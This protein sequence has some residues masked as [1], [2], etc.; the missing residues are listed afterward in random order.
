MAHTNHSH[1]RNS[2]SMDM[3]GPDHWGQLL[4]S[5]PQVNVNMGHFGSFDD[6]LDANGGWPIKFA[7]MFAAHPNLFAD[8]SFVTPPK[9]GQIDNKLCYI[10]ERFPAAKRRL[11]YGTDWHE[12]L[13]DP[14]SYGYLKKWHTAYSTIPSLMPHR[15]EFFGGNAARFLGLQ[16]G[17]SARERLKRT[18][19]NEYKV[20][21]DWESLA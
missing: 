2:N 14:E 16:R 18:L 13:I 15:D 5:Y 17:G 3:T 8:L 1:G 4:R 19:F 9:P 10:I 6:G 12:L 21:P 7:E 20:Q 11:L